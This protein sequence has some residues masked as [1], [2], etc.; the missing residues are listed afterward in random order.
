MPS[1]G[2]ITIVDVAARAGVA[3][4]TVSRAFA[5]PGRVSS[6]TAE[7][8][9]A[10]ARELGYRQASVGQVG[11]QA[12]TAL[13]AAEVADVMN[14]V[15]AAMVKGAYAEAARRGY[16]LVL[17]DTEESNQTE[18]SI[19]ERLVPSVEGFLL[20][21]SRMSDAS[22][23]HIAHMRPTIVL[24]RQV[25]G[26][27]WVCGDSRTGLHEAVDHL[28]GLGHSAFT[29]V[30]GPAASWE[31]GIRWR[32]VADWCK[33]REI[34]ELRRVTG[35]A[36]TLQGGAHSYE[37]W[38]R[39]PTSAVIAYNDLMAIGFI[40]AAVHGGHA[41]PDDVSVIGFDDIPYSSLISPSLT[42][43]SVD[44]FRTGAAAVNA[45]LDATSLRSRCLAQV[46]LPARLRVRESTGPAPHRLR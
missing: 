1:S 12:R 16:Q 31:E 41:V 30:S 4:S 27:G 21:G 37:R 25:P 2:R 36:P 13:L 26:V 5:R 3:P 20:A 46:V 15:F 11:P 42:T 39:A 32:V 23:R 17:V 35:L 18:R 6:E 40:R 19:L 9:F 28:L 34:R 38:R 7:K 22:V 8:I 33:Q 29:Y 24:N 44:R 45:L 10:A 43:L 14:P